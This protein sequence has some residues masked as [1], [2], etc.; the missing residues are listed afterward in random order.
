MTSLMMK[1]LF[2]QVQYTSYRVFLLDRHETWRDSEVMFILICYN[3]MYTF[4]IG[5]FSI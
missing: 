3:E 1:R 5:K 4:N 2:V